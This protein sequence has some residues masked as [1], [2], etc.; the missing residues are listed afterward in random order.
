VAQ[1]RVRSSESV[2]TLLFA[3]ARQVVD[4]QDLITPAPDLADRRTAFLHE[5][6]NILQDFNYVG[7]IA[8]DQFVARE[9]KARQDRLDSQ[10][11]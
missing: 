4:D 10:A 8:R 9:F 3:T 2:S 6:R 7:R 11:R 5:L 1:T